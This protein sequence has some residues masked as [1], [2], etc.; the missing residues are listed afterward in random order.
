MR[1]TSGTPHPSVYAEAGAVLDAAAGDER[2][3]ALGADLLAVLVVVVAPVG[4]EPVG[5]AS[6]PTTTAAY[7]RDGVEQ[8][9]QLGDVVAVGA[10]QR[11]GQGHAAAVGDQVVLGARSG[12]VDRARTGLGPPFTALIDEESTAARD[13]SNAP[14]ACNF[15]SSRSCNRGQTPASFQSRS[16]RQQV[17]PD[18]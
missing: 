18:P 5:P 6:G 17:M 7:R 10:S 2:P 8:R 14:A 4:V 3:D 9:Q 13:Q 16:R 12:A 1:P 11:H 15:A